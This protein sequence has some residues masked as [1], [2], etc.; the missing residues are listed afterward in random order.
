MMKWHNGCTCHKAS[1]ESTLRTPA[2][3]ISGVDSVDPGERYQGDVTATDARIR[4]R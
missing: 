1:T 4:G 2:A 3:H